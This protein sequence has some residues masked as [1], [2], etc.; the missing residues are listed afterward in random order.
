MTDL[1]IIVIERDP[2][3]AEDI[4]AA[5]GN[6]FSQASFRVFSDLEEARPLMSPEGALLLAIISL[7]HNQAVH[8]SAGDR[9]ALLGQA[10]VLIDGDPATLPAGVQAW[11]QIFKPFTQEI[12]IAASENALAACIRQRPRAGNGTECSAKG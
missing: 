9:A 11:Q 5:L 2:F 7:S 1:T 10:V 6:R 8:L 4:S 3:V 12:L